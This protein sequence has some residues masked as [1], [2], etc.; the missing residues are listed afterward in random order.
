M[1]EL[2]KIYHFFSILEQFV[3][4]LSCR[5]GQALCDCFL[6]GKYAPYTPQIFSETHTY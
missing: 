5:V 6:T 2:N 3:F 1:V 4:F